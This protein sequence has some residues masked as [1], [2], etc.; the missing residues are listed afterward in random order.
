MN[1]KL[2]SASLATT[3]LATLVLCGPSHAQAAAQANNSAPS[4]VVRYSDLDLST[5]TGVRTLYQRIRRAAW[6]VCNQMAPVHNAAS[7]IENS[8]CRQTLVD[9]AVGQVHNSALTALHTG[10]QVAALTASR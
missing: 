8:Q 9:D 10:K 5:R 2:S 3:L 1:A 7:G 4:Q 6:Q